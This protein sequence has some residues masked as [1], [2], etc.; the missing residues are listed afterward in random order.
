[1]STTSR[2][3]VEA[4]IK[5]VTIL[6]GDEMSKVI[7]LSYC[8]E[9]ELSLQLAKEVQSS[10]LK[11]RKLMVSALKNNMFKSRESMDV[12]LGFVEDARLFANAGSIAA[13]AGLRNKAY[14][15]EVT[16]DQK[17]ANEA[18]GYMI[19]A[20]EELLRVLKGGDPVIASKKLS[21]A[22][23][24]MKQISGSPADNSNIDIDH[25]TNASAIVDGIAKRIEWIN[26]AKNKENTRRRS[27]SS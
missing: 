7:S 23:E 27:I 10:A 26:N 9:G 6:T 20:V 4:L 24:I 18:V 16:D 3:P 13:R 19:A 14:G 22:I 11:A 12:G 15:A 2:K 1:M 21:S 25:I 5:E 8:G 17:R